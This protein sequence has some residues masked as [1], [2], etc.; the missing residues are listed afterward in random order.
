MHRWDILTFFL[1]LLESN[2]Y[3][4]INAKQK[5]KKEKKD[6]FRLLPLQTKV[7]WNRSQT[8]SGLNQNVGVSVTFF[9]KST[10][11]EEHLSRTIDSEVQ[12]HK[13]ATLLDSSQV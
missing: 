6:L 11:A 4:F 7:W 3:I 5:K 2:L 12:Q 13:K 1:F 8:F 10:P 9:L